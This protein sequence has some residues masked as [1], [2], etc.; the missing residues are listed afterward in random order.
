MNAKDM[1][2]M[3]ERQ[4]PKQLNR[5]TLYEFFENGMRPSANDF[6]DLIFST[7]NK[8]DDGISKSFKHGL[9][10]SPQGKDGEQ[11]ISFYDHID[12]GAPTWTIGLKGPK[13]RKKLFIKSGNSEELL[14]TLTPEGKIG[15]GNAKPERTLDIN[16][17]LGV[18]GTID[19]AGRTGTFAQ[20]TINANGTWQTIASGLKG[21]TMFE[22][23]ALAKGRPG[24]G[25]YAFLH[26]IASNA[27]NGRK[28]NFRFTRNHYEWWKWWKRLGLRWVG[29][30]RNYSLQMKT[31]SNYGRAAKI[32]YHI[33]QLWKDRKP[34][35]TADGEGH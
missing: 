25:N 23:V 7:I 18:N 33:T 17:D 29:S 3:G 19:M 20:G 14:L 30:S 26:A 15:I 10:L 13:D 2:D 9:E 24:M 27:F 21:C 8:I 5:E 1:E 16:G 35:T 28:G 31:F 34:K 6:K 11:V 4:S 22:V 12:G 32:E